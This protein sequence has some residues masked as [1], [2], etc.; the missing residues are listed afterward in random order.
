MVQDVHNTIRAIEI[1]E[2]NHKEEKGECGCD[3]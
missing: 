1:V 3:V 2:T